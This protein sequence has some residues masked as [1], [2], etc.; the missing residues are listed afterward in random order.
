MVSLLVGH[1]HRDFVFSTTL[2]DYSWTLFRKTP[3]DVDPVIYESRK[4]MV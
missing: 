3:H 4:W 1:L 2:K